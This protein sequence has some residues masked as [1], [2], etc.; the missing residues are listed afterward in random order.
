M[1]FGRFCL[2]GIFCQVITCVCPTNLSKR[3]ICILSPSPWLKAFLVMITLHFPYPSALRNYKIVFVNLPFLPNGKCPTI[4]YRC[5]IISTGLLGSISS[6]FLIQKRQ[7]YILFLVPFLPKVSI[8]Q[9][10]KML[11]VSWKV[12]GKQTVSR[13]LALLQRLKV[14][15]SPILAIFL[16]NFKRALKAADP[17]MVPEGLSSENFIDIIMM[18]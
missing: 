18:L 6:K 4:F 3:N 1:G 12:V 10:M 5:N 17:D 15:P 9:V 16:K 8:L 13:R 14:L 7:P 11:L 2:A